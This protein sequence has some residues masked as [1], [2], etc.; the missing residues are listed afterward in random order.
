MKRLNDES[1]N[2]ALVVVEGLRDMRALRSIGFEGSIMMFC[3]NGGRNTL[4]DEAAKYRKTILLLDLDQEGRSL[5]K[6]AALLLEE[7]KSVIDL[8]FRRE[9]A[10]VTRGRVRHIEEL[11]RFKDHLQPYNKM[12][13]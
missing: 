7:K 4:V 10:S 12:L 5:T 3:H 1:L 9:L 8:F 2:G 11:S 13:E 6:K